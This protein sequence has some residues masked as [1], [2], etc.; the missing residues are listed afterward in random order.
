MNEQ[1]TFIDRLVFKHQP[2]RRTYRNVSQATESKWI[3]GT[4]RIRR[5]RA[6]NHEEAF[7]L[8]WSYYGFPPNEEAT[9]I[10]TGE[11]LGMPRMNH[12]EYYGATRPFVTFFDL[13][14]MKNFIAVM[15]EEVPIDPRDAGDNPFY[16]NHEG[17]CKPLPETAAPADDI[18]PRP[19][20]PAEKP[21]RAHQL[22]LFRR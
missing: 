5:F 2:S 17:Q 20:A 1:P 3:G 12:Q 14:K 10:E 4:S 18:T 16:P 21:I 7:L 8:A 22:S 9:K 13:S 19:Q 6:R 11:P 15:V